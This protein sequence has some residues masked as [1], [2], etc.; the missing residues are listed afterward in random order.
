MLF[1]HRRDQLENAN[2]AEL[3]NYKEEVE[4]HNKL[5][6]EVRKTWNLK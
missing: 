1:D 3:A 6:K 4:R 5:L 2:V